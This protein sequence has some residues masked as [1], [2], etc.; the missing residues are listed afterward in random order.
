MTV[1]AATTGQSCC[2]VKSAAYA[3]KVFRWLE[4]KHH[5]GISLGKILV[6]NKAMAY[7]WI[8][9]EYP[10]RAEAFKNDKMIELPIQD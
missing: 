3:F 9:D 1:F 6:A 5:T 7:S 4:F 8:I 10:F 2:Q